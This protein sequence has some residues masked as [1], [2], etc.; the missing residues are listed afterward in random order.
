MAAG[1]DVIKFY[2]DYRRKI[3]RFPPVQAH[4]Y[5][6][7]MPFPPSDP[8]PQVVMFTQE[9]MN[10]IVEEATMAN[11][12]VACHAGTEKGAIMAAKA[13]VT[14]IEH[15]S[16]GS[17]ALIKA[18][19]HHDTIYVPTLAATEAIRPEEVPQAQAWVRKVHENGVTLAA[20]GDTGVFNHG[21]G[22]REMELMIGAGIP[23]EKVLQ[24]GTLGGWKACGGVACGYE[25]GHF[26][27]GA[28]ADI[29]ALES[30]PRKDATALRRVSFVMKDGKVWKNAFY[31]IGIVEELRRECEPLVCSWEVV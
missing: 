14:T 16:V 3:M 20:G 30:D 2:A 15:G 21:D 28:R 25:F 6:G 31:P 11:L 23:V 9:E 22:A 13:G 18:M 8:N 24:A 27:K 29:I 5:I 19:Q 10:A 17:E 26:K 4:P 12:P 1:A 7:G